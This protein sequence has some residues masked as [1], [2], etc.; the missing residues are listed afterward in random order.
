[1]IENEDA[2][3]AG[4]AVAEKLMAQLNGVAPHAV[5]MMDCCDSVELKEQAIK[6]VSSVIDSKLILRRRGLRRLHSRR[7]NK[8]RWHFFTRVS[9]RRFASSSS[10][11]HQNERI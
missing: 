7:R 4:K 1:M 8:L 2:F 3:A 9:G 11:N 6:G 5:L 10:F